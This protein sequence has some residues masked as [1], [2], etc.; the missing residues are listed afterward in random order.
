MQ[1]NVVFKPNVRG[2]GSRGLRLNVAAYVTFE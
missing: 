2:K 1:Q